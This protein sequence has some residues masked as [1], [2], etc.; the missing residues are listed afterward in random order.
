MNIEK[1]Q[2]KQ[3]LD[4]CELYER[5]QLSLGVLCLNLERALDGLTESDLAAVTERLAGLQAA[6]ELPEERQ[7]YT[8]RE[9]T[10]E[11]RKALFRIP[12]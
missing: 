9:H 12:E 11:L 2:R 10:R 4:A 3:I 5:G 6:Q 1:T 7:D 8:A